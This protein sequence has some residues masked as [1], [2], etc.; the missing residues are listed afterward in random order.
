MFVKHFRPNFCQ[1][2]LYFGDFLSKLSQITR[3]RFTGVW[4]LWQWGVRDEGSFIQVKF[5]YAIVNKNG[6]D[7]H[8]NALLYFDLTKIRRIIPTFHVIQGAK[9]NTVL[10]LIVVQQSL[11]VK[12]QPYLAISWPNICKILQNITGI[13]KKIYS[14]LQ[15]KCIDG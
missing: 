1:N 13:Y 11:P 2:Q 3:K 7:C 10:W 12:I 9:P 6:S 4:Q 14:G 15:S 8:K 5:I